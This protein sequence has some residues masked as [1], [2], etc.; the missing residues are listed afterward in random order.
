MKT[1]RRAIRAAG[2]ASTRD[3][4]VRRFAAVVLVAFFAGVRGFAFVLATAHYCQGRGL[5][6]KARCIRVRRSGGTCG[7]PPPTLTSGSAAVGQRVSVRSSATR[8]S[9]RVIVVTNS[10][11]G[12]AP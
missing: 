1:P 10:V 3:F 11:G 8:H 6:V 5:G 7:R 2:A 12:G 4:T 9:S